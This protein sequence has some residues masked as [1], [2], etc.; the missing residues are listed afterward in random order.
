METEI[1]LMKKRMCVGEEIN[2]DFQ[3]DIGFEEVSQHYALFQQEVV[4]ITF[5]N[6]TLGPLGKATQELN[7]T[8]TRHQS[9]SERQF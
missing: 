3:W 9:I 5:Q 7:Q 2:T 4:I 8:E 6:Y 1:C